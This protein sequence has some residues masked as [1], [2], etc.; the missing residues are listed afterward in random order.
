M[1]GGISYLTNQPKGFVH[2]LRIGVFAD[3]VVHPTTLS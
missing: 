1:I 3:L 2:A